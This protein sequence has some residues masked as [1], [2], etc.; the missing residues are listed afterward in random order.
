MPKSLKSL[1]DLPRVDKIEIETSLLI[2]GVAIKHKD[3]VICLPKPMRHHNVIRYMIHTLNI[4]PPVGH[5]R[6][7]G[8]GFYLESGRYL[9]REEARQV[10]LDSGQCKNPDHSIELFSEDL[11]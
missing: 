10:A 8:Q 4:T 5:D 2:I 11:W 9:N 3:L 6:P 1:K 7:D